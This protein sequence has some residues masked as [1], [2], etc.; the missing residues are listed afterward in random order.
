MSELKCRVTAFAYFQRFGGA[1]FLAV[2]EY[3]LTK[4]FS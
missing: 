4:I 2:K 1:P 3:P